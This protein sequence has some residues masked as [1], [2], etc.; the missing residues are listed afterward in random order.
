TGQ[1]G[2]VGRMKT[3][4]L[5]PLLKEL[6]TQMGPEGSAKEQLIGMIE[7]SY[8]QETT[9]AAA[10]QRFVH[11]LLGRFGIVVLDPDHPGLKASIQDVIRDDIF[12]HTAESLVDK[13]SA[14]LSRHYTAQ[15]FVRPVNFFYLK[16]HI[17]ERIV[18]E[19]ETFTVN[20][21]E[22]HFSKEEILRE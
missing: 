11:E 18:Q 12:Y 5:H 7:Q 15:A 19:K 4:D 20:H 6:F 3:H 17:R 10:T 8:G 2:A 21:T 16:D 9:I 13:T 1:Q 14:A 22:I